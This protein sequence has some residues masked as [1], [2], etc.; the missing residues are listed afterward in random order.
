MNVIIGLIS[1]A[2][3]FT[4]VV[5]LEKIFKKEGLFIWIAISVVMANIAVC[6]QVNFFGFAT[7]LG[8]VLFASSFL[9]TD[10]IN[11]KYSYKDSK[12]AILL[13]VC[14]QIIFIIITQFALLYIPS[15][16]DQVNNA[17]K[18]LFSINLR[19]S[20]ASITM[21]FVSNMADIYLYKKI[22]EK[23]PNKLWLRNNVST[24]VTNCL[25][26]YLFSILA[27]TGI[28]SFSIIISIATVA[29]IIEMIIALC[30]TPFLYLAVRKKK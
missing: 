16:T 13:G 5:L 3:C 6:K 11:E 29:S 20:I 12:K 30:D 8:S 7:S 2:L 25:E 15:S 19:V 28:Y 21:Y 1:I 27:F 17:M 10:I 22:K 14:S 26:N 18:T 24:I 9:A 4:T 23:I